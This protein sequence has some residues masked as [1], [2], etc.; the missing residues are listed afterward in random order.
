MTINI[1]SI[2]MRAKISPQVVNKNSNKYEWQ[3]RISHGTMKIERFNCVN[4]NIQRPL[5]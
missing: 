1:W 2:D 4:N 3:A 5:D